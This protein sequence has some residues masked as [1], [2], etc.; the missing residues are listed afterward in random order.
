MGLKETEKREAREC[1]VGLISEIIVLMRNVGESKTRGSMNQLI[2]RP[3][4]PLV[5]KRTDLTIYGSNDLQIYG[6][7]D[8]ARYQSVTE[9]YRTSY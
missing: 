7:V 4:N 6:S 3:G 9:Q 2:Y 1:I 5:C 8:L